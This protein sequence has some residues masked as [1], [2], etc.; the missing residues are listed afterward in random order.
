MTGLIHEIEHGLFLD[1]GVKAV[2]AKQMKADFD[3]PLQR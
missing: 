3:T 2:D 1:S